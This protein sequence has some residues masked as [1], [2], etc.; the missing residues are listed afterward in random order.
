MSNITFMVSQSIGAAIAPPIFAIR[1][2]RW[3]C[4]R[5]NLLILKPLVELILERV[6]TRYIINMLDIF[7][8][9]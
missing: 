1:F 5:F 8:V 2:T 6:F 7:F 9:R 4:Y 3:F